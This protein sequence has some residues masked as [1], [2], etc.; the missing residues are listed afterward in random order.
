[1]LGQHRQVIAGRHKGP[2]KVDRTAFDQLLGKLDA[3]GGEELLQ[4]RALPAAHH[5]TDPGDLRKNSPVCAPENFAAEILQPYRGFAD[6]SHQRKRLC[7]TM[8]YAWRSK[9]IRTGGPVMANWPL[10]YRQ[11]SLHR[12]GNW[13]PEKIRAT[14]ADVA[15]RTWPPVLCFLLKREGHRLHRAVLF[16]SARH[17]RD[18]IDVCDRT[19]RRFA[20]QG[21]WLV[22]PILQPN[23][24]PPSVDGPNVYIAAACYQLWLAAKL[25]WPYAA[26]HFRCQND[27]YGLN[28]G[29]GLVKMSVGLHS[30]ID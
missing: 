13:L 11:K 5:R 18:G 15:A 9:D 25:C 24:Q 30:Q 7:I 23:I 28:D 19:I 14:A 26:A 10:K 2:G 1:M 29:D 6:S 21:V 22:A 27:L 8:A 17:R 12:A 20:G 16:R 4:N 3:F